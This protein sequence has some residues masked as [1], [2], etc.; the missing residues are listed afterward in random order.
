MRLTLRTLLAYLDD[1]LGPEEAREIGR[2]VAQSPAAQELIERIKKVTRRR[3]LKAPPPTTDDPVTDPN[4]VAEYLDNVLPADD[5]T[6]FEEVAQGSDPLLAEVAAC[7][8]ILTLVLGEPAKVPPTARQRMYR[9]VKGRE[10]IPYRRPSNLPSVARVAEPEAADPHEGDEALL[11]G[12]PAYG[13]GQS[14]SRRL[15]PVAG[16]LLVLAGLIFCIWMLIP[17][18][19]QPPATN[20]YVAVNPRGEQ[21]T[22]VILPSKEAG[23]ENGAAKIEPDAAK[24]SAAADKQGAVIEPGAATVN[25]NAEVGPPPR[26]VDGAGEA[27]VKKEPLVVAAP[28]PAVDRVG[29]GAVESRATLLLAK[30]PDTEIWQRVL[31]TAPKIFS[32][33]TLVS[34][35]GYHTDVRLDTGVR[36]Q[37][38]GNLPDLLDLPMLESKVIL[39]APPSGFDADIR[40]EG[41]RVFM[42]NPGRGGKTGPA[43]VRVRFKSE[44]WDVTLLDDKTEVCVDL[45]GRYLPGVPFSKN[46]GGEAPYAEFDLG[47][48]SGHAGVKLGFK[49]FPDIPAPSQM[50][51]DNKSGLATDPRR[52]PKEALEFWSKV[53][54]VKSPTQSELEAGLADFAKRITRPDVLVDVEFT[55][56]LKD[57]VN[58]RMGRRVLAVLFLQAIDA[59][60]YVADALSDD[61]YPIRYAATVALRHWTAQAPERDLQLYQLLVDKKRYSENH[62][63]QVMQLLHRFADEKADDL[64][65]HALLFDLMGHER[66]AVREL[67]FGHL[68][69]MDPVGAKE[70][71]FFDAA[72]P[73]NVRQAT[74]ER[75]KAS[76]K[77]RFVDKKK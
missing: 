60:G 45:F 47:I 64:E 56:A 43:K 36:L 14:P 21:S 6:Q 65:T 15:I 57:D 41:G 63:E 33:D 76:W 34:L 35:P 52:V 39:Y 32:T 12:L 77:K 74:I 50:S 44:V 54:T 38:W 67:A 48:L 42:T 62:A 71:G 1:T 25:P 59:L 75:W 16:F 49:E 70:V 20:G 30:E 31:P 51:W 40:L 3:G 66:V 46:P 55:S 9:L 17:P 27:A 24:T 22:A 10:S 28:K 68:A 69:R 11:L 13:R 5:L 19:S 61:Q 58:E 18:A 8:Q 2:K 72:A 7:H 23:K 29:V 26:H 53:P 37:L 73:D 4:T